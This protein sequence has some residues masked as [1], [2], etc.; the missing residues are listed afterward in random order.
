M[1][2]IR[3]GVCHFPPFTYIQNNA[4]FGPWIWAVK[5]AVPSGYEYDF[6]TLED[7]NCTMS[8][9]LD[10][11]SSSLFDVAVHPM[12]MDSECDSCTWSY[13]LSSNGLVTV[14]ADDQSARLNIFLNVFPNTVWY[15]I[16]AVATAF[17]ISAVIMEWHRARFNH[18]A[19]SFLSL[20]ANMHTPNC[21]AGGTYVLYA[22]MVIF[23]SMILALYT[24]ELIST[25]LQEKVPAGVNIRGVVNS[26]VPFS[27]VDGGPS[28]QIA[29]EYPDATYSI[30]PQSSAL[31]QSAFPT[32][33]LYEQGEMLT[34]ASCD[35]VASKSGA[36]N[37]I[38]YSMAFREGF[39][40]REAM[41]L[42]FREVSVSDTMEATMQTWITQKYSCV[43]ESAVQLGLDFV[44]PFLWIS[45]G[46]YTTSVLFNVIV[47]RNFG[48]QVS[49]DDE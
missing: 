22:N 37:R 41:N 4:V 46:M 35:P 25:I 14:T 6:V 28:Q 38:A 11:L 27:V 44:L 5:N 49:A 32:L 42:Y 12:A 1:D 34:K 8:N 43:E 39:D 9:M 17:M 7:E 2:A 24:A 16:G 45:L 3:L 23:T 40:Q 29:F 48:K 30:L 47:E 18:V 20:M 21:I 31:L 13:P 33:M 10:G 15:C 36:I 19:Y 26:G